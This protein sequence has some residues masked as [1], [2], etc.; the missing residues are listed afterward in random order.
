MWFAFKLCISSKSLI[1][2]ICYVFEMSYWWLCGYD[3][4]KQVRTIYVA[5]RV[6][7]CK[8]LQVM[9]AFG[10]WQTSSRLIKIVVGLWFTSVHKSLLVIFH[11]RQRDS[12][13]Q[14]HLSKLLK[15][16][17]WRNSTVQNS[18]EF[19][20]ANAHVINLLCVDLLRQNALIKDVSFVNRFSTTTTMNIL[21]GHWV[22]N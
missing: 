21:E 1:L 16:V 7:R 13:A 10:P 5:F 18:M 11:R 2:I 17:D 20:Q 14:E 9:I 6:H 15:F 12:R 19:S 4:W 8:N 3:S 22:F